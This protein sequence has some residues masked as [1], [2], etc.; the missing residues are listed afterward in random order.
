MNPAVA[1]GARHAAARQ[2]EN[3][4]AVQLNKLLLQF[5]QVVKRLPARAPLLGQRQEANLCAC[6][7]R[8]RVHHKI[9]EG[10][11][12]CLFPPPAVGTIPGAR[13]G[14]RTAGA[15]SAEM[16]AR[17][18]PAPMR[19][20][21]AQ[22]RRH[23]Y[24]PGRAWATAFALARARARARRARRARRACRRRMRT[25]TAHALRGAAA[26][27]TRARAAAAHLDGARRR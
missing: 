19:G 14:Q 1:R 10:K 3:L 8:W 24:A 16:R 23:A 26:Q 25:G 20:L 7:R 2:R 12:P 13:A 4:L 9:V 5:I 11:C 18:A 15:K 27:R 22:V 17:A 21:P 6:R